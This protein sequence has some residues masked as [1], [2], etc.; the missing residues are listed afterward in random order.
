MT[1]EVRVEGSAM[2]YVSRAVSTVSSTMVDKC[3]L[4]GIESRV[5]CML[6]GMQIDRRVEYQVGDDRF[7][8]Y[9]A[10]GKVVCRVEYKVGEQHEPC[11][12]YNGC[13]LEPRVESQVGD[14]QERR[15]EYQH[16]RRVEYHVKDEL[17]QNMVENQ[18]GQLV[19][20]VNQV[21]NQQA[22][23]VPIVNQVQQEQLVPIVNQVQHAPRLPIVNQVDLPGVVSRND[24]MDENDHIEFAD[25]NMDVHETLQIY[26]AS[27][28]EV[29]VL[30]KKLL[31][32]RD[33]RGQDKADYNRCKKVRRQWY[34]K[35]NKRIM[36]ETQRRAAVQGVLAIAALPRQP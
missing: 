34:A 19:P 12:W 30:Y 14:Q 1:D 10:N 29:K 21:E 2:T 11:I 33:C 22:Q 8:E 4:V 16:E 27:A 23:L 15:V 17:M 3:V 5:D 6:D 18:Q 31:A 24:V 20:I 13:Q 26:E 36:K 9:E 28:K 32:A 25:I 35:I 7:I